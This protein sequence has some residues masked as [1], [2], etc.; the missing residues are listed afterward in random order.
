MF[1]VSMLEKFGIGTK[2]IEANLALGRLD[3]TDFENLRSVVQ[4]MFLQFLQIN[5]VLSA[6]RTFDNGLLY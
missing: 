2:S 6:N 5:K 3:I 4:K 1:V